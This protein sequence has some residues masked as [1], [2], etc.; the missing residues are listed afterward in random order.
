M[1]I[2]SRKLFACQLGLAVFVMSAFISAI[3][4]AAQCLEPIGGSEVLIVRADVR[5]GALPQYVYLGALAVSVI[6]AFWFNNRCEE[7]QEA[8]SGRIK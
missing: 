7:L 1:H 2:K 3:F 4:F 8:P 5:E 6:L